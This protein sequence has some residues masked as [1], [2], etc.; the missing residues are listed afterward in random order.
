MQNYT[1]ILPPDITG[2]ETIALLAPVMLPLLLC[3][4]IIGI[5]ATYIAKKKGYSGS[6]LIWAWVP[7]LNIY[8]LIM[9]LGLP[10]LFLRARV[11]AVAAK[12]IPP[13]SPRP[14]HE[15]RP[16]KLKNRHGG[17]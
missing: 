4:V 1:K 7:V 10:N 11:D 17:I 16:G 3:L 6:I 9:I 2:L 8:G 12:L 5:F 15:P 13:G 14:E